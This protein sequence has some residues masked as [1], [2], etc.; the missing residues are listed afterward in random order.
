MAP[1]YLVKF[2]HDAGL[3]QTQNLENIFVS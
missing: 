2:H 1:G 3:E